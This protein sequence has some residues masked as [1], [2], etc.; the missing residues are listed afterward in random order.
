MS[1]RSQIKAFRKQ[2]KMKREK[3][4]IWSI[5]GADVAYVQNYKVATRSIRLA[6]AKYMLEQD[7]A[8]LGYDEIDKQMVISLRKKYS[9][10]YTVEQYKSKYPHVSTFTFVRNPLNRLYSCYV[11]KITDRKIGG[12]ENELGY[13]GITLDTS[14]EDFVRI[15]ADTP[16]DAANRHFRSQSWF[17][18]NGNEVLVDF[19]G[20]LESL[21]EDW[22]TLQE[23]YGFP[24]LPHLNKSTPS[25][26]HI[27]DRYT[28]ETYSMA[29]S[30]YEKDIE[31]LG[32]SEDV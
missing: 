12:G 8:N 21:S 27:R 16:D 31:L 5:H 23:R 4:H 18:T 7:G 14:F 20:K 28:K 13:W 32:Y 3:P 26:T 11:N 29:L 2:R 6:L 19:I 15:I 10:L 9:G 1:I 17:V 22:K 30:R 24:S 25:K